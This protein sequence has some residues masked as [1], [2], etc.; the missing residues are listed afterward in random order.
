MKELEELLEELE[1]N[2]TEIKKE[3]QKKKLFKKE[4]QKKCL[5]QILLSEQK[6][7]FPLFNQK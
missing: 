5:S 7:E 3:I 1:N 4:I 2:I 6:Q